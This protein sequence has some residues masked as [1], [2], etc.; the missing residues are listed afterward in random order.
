MSKDGK[1]RRKKIYLWI[2]IGAMVV[3]KMSCGA[4]DERGRGVPVGL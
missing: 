3:V 2:C 4:E 1:A